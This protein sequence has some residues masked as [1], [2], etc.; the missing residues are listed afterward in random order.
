MYLSYNYQFLAWNEHEI[1]FQI[2]KHQLM[3]QFKT[4]K[5]NMG[6]WLSK[7]CE[8]GAILE[9]LVVEPINRYIYSEF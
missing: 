2:S 6:M 3:V 9:F 5:P 7:F 1:Q 4:I 8:V